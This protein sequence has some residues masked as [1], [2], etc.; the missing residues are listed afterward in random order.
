MERFFNRILRTTGVD[1]EKFYGYKEINDAFMETY[2][3]AMN[4]PEHEQDVAIEQAFANALRTCF[5]LEPDGNG[6][7]GATIFYKRIPDAIDHIQK[8]GWV[9][10]LP[11]DVVRSLGL[12][13]RYYKTQDPKDQVEVFSVITHYL[14]NYPV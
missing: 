1:P 7:I 10:P 6:Y 12:M 2:K 5:K 13:R 11:P 3:T 8:Q 4:K 9:G 14:S